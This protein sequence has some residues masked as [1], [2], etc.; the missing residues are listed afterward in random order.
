M[1]R[2]DVP[3]CLSFNDRRQCHVNHVCSKRSVAVQTDAVP[4]MPPLV[5][6]G[7]LD[8][9]GA[10]ATGSGSGGAAPLEHAALQPVLHQLSQRLASVEAVLGVESGISRSPVLE[11][12]EGCVSG[13]ESFS[14][15]IMDDSFRGATLGARITALEGLVAQRSA[16]GT[17]SASS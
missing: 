6:F 3:V 5:R 9:A 10:V 13:V 1:S 12:F 2:R 17:S 7:T 8:G 15:L 11:A 16:Q 4:G 14:G